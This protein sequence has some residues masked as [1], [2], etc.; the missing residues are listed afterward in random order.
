MRL[1]NTRDSRSIFWSTNITSN[2]GLRLVS[3]PHAKPFHKLFK[4]VVLMLIGLKRRLADFRQV[5]SE[6]FVPFGSVLMASVLTNM[7]RIGSR[8]LCGRRHGEPTMMSS[9]PL[10]LASNVLYAARST[11][12]KVE[13]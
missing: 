1:F 5:I 3:Q 4:R 10:N 8:S 9:C 13:P 12:Y 11:I 6:P 7:P 2:S